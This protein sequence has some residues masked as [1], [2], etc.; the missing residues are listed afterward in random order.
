MNPPRSVLVV[1]QGDPLKSHRPVEALRIALGLASGDAPVYV[2]LL[3]GA[4]R[5]LSHDLDDVVDGEILENYLPSLKDLS[6][7]FLIPATL[8]GAYRLDDGFSIER[9]SLER[10]TAAVHTAE[11]T[12]IF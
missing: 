10:L 6:L 12:L 5:L 3:D 9:V 4:V 7:P 11:R 2:M 8:S 1:V